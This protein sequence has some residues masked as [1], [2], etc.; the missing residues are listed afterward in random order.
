MPTQ[1]PPRRR[2][3]QPG[4]ANALKHGFTARKDRPAPTRPV[5]IS[6]KKEQGVVPLTDAEETALLRSLFSWI[7]RL[8]P[9]PT[10]IIT[11]YP[12]LRRLLNVFF[13]QVAS[14]RAQHPLLT[15]EY[16]AF[17]ANLEQ[18]LRHLMDP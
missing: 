1:P 15:E 3:A 5:I 9:D 10:Y 18:L 14:S 13:L 16:E 7:A 8:Y 12:I 4:N 2:G 11:V 6:S 17:S